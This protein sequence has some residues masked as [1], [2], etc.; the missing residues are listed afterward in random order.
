[1]ILAGLSS[2]RM[3][4]RMQPDGKFLVSPDDVLAATEFVTG[5]FL[6][7]AQTRHASIYEGLFSTA[8][9]DTPYPNKLTL[10]Y[11]TQQKNPSVTIGGPATR[12]DSSALSAQTVTLQPP[13]QRTEFT[14]PTVLL[15]YRIVVDKNG[16]MSGAYSNR[17]RLWLPQQRSTTTLLEFSLPDV[18][19]PFRASGGAIS[20]RI[21]AGARKVKMSVGDRDAPSLIRTLNSPAGLFTIDVPAQHLNPAVTKGTLY[22]ELDVGDP[23]LDDP[24]DFPDGAREDNWH[25]GRLMLTLKGTRVP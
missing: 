11:W 2:E 10:L 1:M 12:Q 19:Q 16:G 18:C 4:V 24:D 23:D 22:V 17:E 3:A 21:N 14:I 15:P 6:T 7:D 20:I 25:I 13:P 8:Q 9:H 5:T